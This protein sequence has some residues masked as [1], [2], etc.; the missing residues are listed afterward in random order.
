MKEIGKL[1]Q[2]Q[3]KDIKKTQSILVVKS[4]FSC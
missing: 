3:Y 1:S 4:I 2:L